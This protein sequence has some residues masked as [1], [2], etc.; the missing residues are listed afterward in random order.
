MSCEFSKLAIDKSSF[1]YWSSIMDRKSCKV[2]GFAPFGL[3][4][5]RLTHIIH[6]DGIV[7]I[8]FSLRK[9]EN[10]GSRFV[11]RDAGGRPTHVRAH[12]AGV[13]GQHSETAR[14]QII[15]QNPGLHIERGLRHAIGKLTFAPAAS[16]TA[17]LRRDVEDELL[18][19]I[20][21]QG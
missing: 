7:C 15:M 5:Q 19:A 16:D 6:V 13:N 8:P 11:R 3:P 21:E 18:S 20:F 1:E 2:S 12:P 9:L 14:F 17:R 4:R 10:S